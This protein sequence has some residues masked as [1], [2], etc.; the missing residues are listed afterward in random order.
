MPLTREQIEAIKKEA[1][2]YKVAVD[3]TGKAATELWK[4]RIDVAIAAGEATS[5][6]DLV[7][8]GDAVAWGNGSCPTNNGCPSTKLNPGDMGMPL[9]Q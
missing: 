2:N 3:Q 8:P 7:K 6:D 4:A 9:K 1:E 5:I